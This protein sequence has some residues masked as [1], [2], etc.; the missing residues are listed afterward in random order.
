MEWEMPGAQ[1]TAEGR[2][3]LDQAAIGLSGLCLVHCIGSAIIVALL[4]SA[5]GILLHPVIH[6]IGLAFAIALAALGL[7]RGFLAHGF[8]LPASIGVA[9]LGTMAAALMVPHGRSEVVFTIIG[10]A[11]VAIGH[12]LNRRALA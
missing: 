10:V 11:L 3:W 7:G 12:H 8:V 6:E 2:S 9:G 4:A 5:G 1:Q